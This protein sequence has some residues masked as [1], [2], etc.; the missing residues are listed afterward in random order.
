MWDEM[1][2][3]GD[4]CF[5]KHSCEL[6][7]FTNNIGDINN[8]LD[9]FEQHCT[10]PSSSKRNVASHMLVFM[11]RGILTSLEFVY[12]QF[13]TTGASADA[14]FPLVWEAVS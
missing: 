3:K 10:N 4:L 11:V 12:A 2:I 13:S 1:K 5:D 14:W 8:Q 6:I 7:G 9:Q